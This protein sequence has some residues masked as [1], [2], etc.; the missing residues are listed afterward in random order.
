MIPFIKMHSLGNDIIILP[1]EIFLCDDEIKRMAH[2]NYGVGCDQIMRI[3]SREGGHR[4][5][6][7]NQDGT[8]ALACGNGT[9][10][11]IEYLNPPY[12]EKMTLEGPVGLLT[13]W[14]TTDGLVHVQQGVP[15]V[16]MIVHKGGKTRAPTLNLTEY[17]YDE[18]VPVSVGNPHLV[19][20]SSPPD[21]SSPLWKALSQHPAFPEGVNV[22]FVYEDIGVCVKT[23]E[24]GVGFTLGCGSAACAVASVLFQGPFFPS[25]LSFEGS[26][27]SLELDMPGGR[28]CVY[29]TD[30][31]IVHAA[32]ATTLFWGWWKKVHTKGPFD[33]FP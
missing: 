6:I 16:G 18:G 2:R 4:V 25:S 9:R 26:F 7:W 32:P 5:R 23:W 1:Q 27:R 8:P 19:V 10:C 15:L 20:C 11:V 14:K 30:Q 13:G 22:S 12:G 31:G 3:E 29:E 33:A 28:M 17:G 24:R 21:P